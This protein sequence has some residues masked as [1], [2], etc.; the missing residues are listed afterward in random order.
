MS[1][2]SQRRIVRSLTSMCS[3]ASRC[4]IML[5]VTP[6][7]PMCSREPVHQLPCGRVV[8]DCLL[9]VGEL[10]GDPK[11]SRLGW[12]GERRNGRCPAVVAYGYAKSPAVTAG[13]TLRRVRAGL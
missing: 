8:A 12:A 13:M 7:S 10:R 6:R 2:A 1:S 4:K 9:D 11:G 5:T 3:L